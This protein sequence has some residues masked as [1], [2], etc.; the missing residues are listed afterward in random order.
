VTGWGVAH[1]VPRGW[2][3]DA[4][5][6]D[7][8]IEHTSDYARSYLEIARE[9]WALVAPERAKLIDDIELRAYARKPH[10]LLAED[11]TALRDALADLESRLRDAGWLDAHGD[12]PADRLPELARRTT[13]LELTGD[14]VPRAAI[15]AALTRV[16]IVSHLLDRA[17]AGGFDVAFD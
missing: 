4:D 1:L 8:A 5:D 11:I 16:A 10:V 14:Y 13:T 9:L 2:D 12:V 17:L 7:D 3:P 15:A 6:A